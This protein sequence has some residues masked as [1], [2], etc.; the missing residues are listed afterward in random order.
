MTT[1]HL[2]STCLSIGLSQRKKW[3]KH[4]NLQHG[5]NCFHPSEKERYQKRQWHQ[6][7]G[8]DDSY[9]LPGMFERG[10]IINNILLMIYLLFV[11]IPYLLVK[12]PL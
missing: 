10:N 12:S 11:S 2:A 5:W 8:S 3:K 6:Q 7:A 4:L 9:P 1:S